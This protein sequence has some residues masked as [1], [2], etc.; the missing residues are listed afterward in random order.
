MARKIACTCLVLAMLIAV[1]ASATGK[2]ETGKEGAAAA[3]G[4]GGKPHYGGTFTMFGNVAEPPSPA[5]KD[6]NHPALEWLEPIQERPIHGDFEKYGPRGNGEYAFQLV[7]YIPPKYQKGHLISKW[8]ITREKM[9][10]TVR[11]GVVWQSVPGVM[12]SRPLTAEDIVKDIIR[13]KE[14]PW[15]GRFKGLLGKVY[16]DGDKVIMEYEQYSPDVFYFLGYEDRA[17][18]SPPE[19]EVA[20][21]DQWKNQGGTGAFKFEEYV[22]GSHMSYVKNPDY[23]D[24]TTI[25]GVEYKLPFVD[26]LVRVIIPDESTAVAALRTAKLD[27]YRNVNNSQ[28]DTLK[29]TSPDLQR[30][31]YGDMVQAIVLKENEPPFNNL[32]VRRALMI[33]TN[34]EVFRKFG[35]AEAFPVHCFPAWPGNPGVYTPMKDLPPE[36]QELYKYDAEKAR[37]MLAD[38]GYPNGFQMDFYI[39]GDDQ[40]NVGFASLLQ[41]EWAKIGVK[42]NVVAHDYVTYRRYR[43]TFT[44]KDAIICGTQI[45]NAVGSVTNL[46]VTNATQIS[47]EMDAEKQDAL[48]KQASVIATAEVANIGTYIVPQGDFWWPWV[49]NFYGE[50][51]IEDGTLGGLIPY[52]WVDQDLKKKMGH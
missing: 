48:I 27:M 17:I 31:T 20:G 8:E 38:A 23:W 14:S 52:I 16:A 18:I 49:K 21:A 47:A 33:G 51:S 22:V 50:V 46:L 19:T 15:G 1:C 12:K 39:A 6:G 26:R 3:A 34:F 45:G 41:D 2:P 43:D 37:K 28:W 9:V 7:A 10:W 30:N 13:F 11:P 29:S 5:I 40:Q 35:R 44:Y 36:A 32:Q 25:D 4:P 24:K 42:V